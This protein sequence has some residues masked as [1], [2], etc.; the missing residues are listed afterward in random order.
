MTY[1]LAGNREEALRVLDSLMEL[2]EQRYVSPRAV[3]FVYVG[4]D[5]LD[6][7]IDWFIQAAVMRDPGVN[8]EVRYVLS[9]RLRDHHRYPELL[10]L[11]RLER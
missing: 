8:S 6:A 3:A 2:R 7:A 10:R 5:S 4:L 11:M 9:D 1:A